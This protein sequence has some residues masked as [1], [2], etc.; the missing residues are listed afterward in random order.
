MKTKILLALLALVATAAAWGN[1]FSVGN[2]PIYA[3]SANM[4]A[5]M[6]MYGTHDYLAQYALQFLPYE[7]RSWIQNNTYFYGTELPDSIGMSESI[8]DRIA[9]FMRFDSRGNLL[10]DSLGRQAMKKYDLLIN[11]LGRD[12]TVT[13][14]KWAGAIAAYVSNAGLFSRVIEGSEKGY[15]FEGYILQMTDAVYPSADFT[16]KFGPYIQFDGSLEMISPYD[17]I[18]RVA[19][20]TS[21]GKK[22]GSCKAQWMEDNYDPEDPQ[23]IACAGR[24]FNNIVN[25]IADVIHTA[26]Q[27]A[28]KAQTYTLY[29]YNWQNYAAA[30]PASEETG[31]ESEPSEPAQPSAP[32]DAGESKPLPQ[33]Q[34]PAQNTTYSAPKTSKKAAGSEWLY[35]L[36]IVIMA[37]IAFVALRFFGRKR[38][39]KSAKSLTTKSSKPAAK[40]PQ[41]REKKL[42]PALAQKKLTPRAA[43]LKEEL[44]QSLESSDLEEDEEGKNDEEDQ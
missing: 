24:N 25:A 11:S 1:G 9:Q 40:K 12:E 8:G 13:A 6:D 28:V 17:A 36:L 18:A 32:A 26:Y 39:V 7:E 16:T 22:D 43:Q 21:M 10:N 38:T 44:K 23:F 3:S 4:W 31:P 19:Q 27:N 29:A 41:T 15:T 20:A 34:Q 42:K 30:Q 2:R 33:P 37:V 14:S 35:I 5:K